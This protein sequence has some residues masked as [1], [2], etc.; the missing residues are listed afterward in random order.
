MIQARSRGRCFRA[1]ADERLEELLRDLGPALLHIPFDIAIL[2][3]LRKP[4]LLLG[5]LQDL[6]HDAP[7]RLLDQLVRPGGRGGR[8]GRGGRGERGERRKGGEGRGEG[9][10]R[11]RREEGGRKEGTRAWE[12]R[13]LLPG[14]TIVAD[15]AG[16]RMVCIRPRNISS[17]IFVGVLLAFG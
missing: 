14:E 12:P 7:P 3:L 2:P 13:W 10:E 15:E 11:G 6:V 16:V 8:A 1:R 9:G 5:S 17:I 4:I